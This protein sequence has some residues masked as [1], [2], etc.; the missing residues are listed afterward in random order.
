MSRN[1]LYGLPGGVTLASGRHQNECIRVTATELTARTFSRAL[2][3]G[4][5]IT[6]TVDA[7]KPFTYLRSVRFMADRIAYYI[8]DKAGAVSLGG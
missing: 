7:V 3:P 8:V 2:R 5:L 4:H 6:K 1:Q